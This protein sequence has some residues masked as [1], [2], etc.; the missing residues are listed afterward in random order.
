[1]VGKDKKGKVQELDV[2][3]ESFTGKE[4]L[5]GECKWRNSFK[6]NKAV[7]VLNESA[8]HFSKY[9]TFKYL[10]TKVPLSVGDGSDA[11]NIFLD[12]FFS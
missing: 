9:K 4:L 11:K 2:V 1:M 8:A 12:I 3:V 10:F 5:I 6:V 7:E